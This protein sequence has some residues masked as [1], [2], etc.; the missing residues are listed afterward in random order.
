MR[1]WGYILEVVRRL[2]RRRWQA[3]ELIVLGVVAGIFLIGAVTIWQ[4]L[5][6]QVQDALDARKTS[7]N[8]QTVDVL[9]VDRA[10]FNYYVPGSSD[11]WTFDKKTA[12]FDKTS[13]IVKYGVKLNYSGT[14]V[15]MT[16]QKFPDDLKP[17]GSTKFLNFI[18]SV[19]PSRSQEA[20]KGTLFF[21][22]TLQNGA[23]ANGSDTVVFATDDVLMFG[24]SASVLGYD[25]WAK[26]MASMHAH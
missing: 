16:Q 5:S 26:L 23:P 15:T 21:K 6:N 2:A 8:V 20:G 4:K 3:R 9:D 13:K 11:A 7:G 25:A 24:R 14:M 19:N 10:D 1:R 12:V 17:R 18:D 22:A